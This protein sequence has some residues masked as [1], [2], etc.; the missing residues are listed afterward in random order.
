[1]SNILIIKEKYLL[2]QYQCQGL[3]RELA[4]F[5]IEEMAI[6][7]AEFIPRLYNFCEELG[8]KNEYTMPSRAFCS[9]ENQGLPILLLAKHFGTFPFNHGLVGGIIAIDR[10]GPHAHH[11][12]DLVIIQASHVGYDPE[13]GI[14]G[15]YCRPRRLNNYASDSCG[16]LANI[17]NPY[18]DEYRFARDHIFLN[19]GHDGKYLIRIKNSFIDFSSNPIK[20]GIVLKLQD[21]VNHGTS[22]GFIQPVSVFSTSHVFE[23]SDEFRKRIDATNYEWKVGDG[24]PIGN[25]LFHDIFYFKE[26]LQETRDSNRI[27]N[28]LLEFM[29]RIVTSEA[30]PLLA[31]Q[32]T[33]QVEFPR[34]VESIR[35]DEVYKGKNLLY[36]AGLNIDIS[37]YKDYPSTTYFVPWAA[38]IQLKENTPK[39]YMHPLEQDLIYKK[40][41]EQEVE[42]PDQRSLKEEI[43]M[44]LDAPRYNIRAPK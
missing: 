21:I 8:F 36:I 29:P 25:L 30:P 15:K 1:M 37:K 23:V 18:I 19:K 26:D 10:N 20:Q 35:K 33:M 3:N 27:H 42:N 14:Y 38:H 4:S 13:T 2:N 28:S 44:M 43:G 40:I 31:A 32:I 41:M 24:E 12:E 22:G 39:E 11:G 34:A 6:P 5:K 7:Y 9:D 17:I 16:K